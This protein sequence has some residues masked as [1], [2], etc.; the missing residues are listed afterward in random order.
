MPF[1]QG[2]FRPR[3]RQKHKGKQLP[4]YRSGW[5]LKFFRWCDLNENVVAWSSEQ[6][7]VPYMNPITNKVSRYFVDGLVSI[8]ESNGIKT[9]LIE[10]KPSKQ[11]RP[12]TVR[13]GQRK[14]TTIYEQKMWVQNQAKWEAA[15]KWCKKK[16]N[17]E[18]KIL[19]EKELGV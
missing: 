4:V 9:Y 7:V 10:I 18:F 1:R 14:T 3:N 19:T 11:T 12:P 13:K 16:G 15:E 2:V 17:V 6:V 8:K 5:E